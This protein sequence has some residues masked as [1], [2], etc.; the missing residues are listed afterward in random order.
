MA[1]SPYVT[2]NR[3]SINKGNLFRTQFINST[4]KI[5]FQLRYLLK[6]SNYFKILIIL[7]KAVRILET[8]GSF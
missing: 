4:H 5:V 7:I 1:S 8:P 6:L 3:I 2:L